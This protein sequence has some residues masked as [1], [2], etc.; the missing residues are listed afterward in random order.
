MGVVISN[1]PIHLAHD[2]DVGNFFTG[3]L[4]S[5]HHVGDFFA[6]RGGA[7]RLPMG[8]AEHGNVGVG[9]RHIA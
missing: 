2:L 4:Q 6:H 9:M 3:C 1:R 5:N 8:A 7:G